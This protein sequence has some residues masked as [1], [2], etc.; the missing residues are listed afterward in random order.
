MKKTFAT[1]L[2]LITLGIAPGEVFAARQFSTGFEWQNTTSGVE[3]VTTVSTPTIS[4]SVKHGGNASLQMTTAVTAK[5]ISWTQGNSTRYYLRYYFYFTPGA[6]TNPILTAGMR[7]A[8]NYYAG[9]LTIEDNGTNPFLTVRAN[10]TSTPIS[11]TATLQNNTWHMVEM[12]IDTLGGT[13]SDILTVRVD[14]VQV[15]NSA[16]QNMVISPSAFEISASNSSGSGDIF[17]LDDIAVD[18]GGVQGLWQGEG[19]IVAAV[20]NAAGFSACTT[21]TFSSINEIPQSDTS[22]GGTDRCEMTVNTG[23]T[24]TFNVTDSSA[25][26]IDSYDTINLLYP[27]ARLN[28]AASNVTVWNILI[29]ANGVATTTSSGFDVGDTTIRTNPIGTINFGNLLVSTTN[30]ATSLAW[31]PTGS[32]SIDS[33]KIGITGTDF[34]PD[35]YMQTFAVMIEYRDANL[36]LGPLYYSVGKMI[37]AKGKMSI[38]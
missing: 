11:N 17:Y 31:T 5:S 16:T 13:N 24:A 1:L 22:T 9:Y 20:P 33:M 3:W 8:S 18:P 26:G 15:A 34:N 23:Q 6:G 38:I 29:S 19:K 35:V 37:I 12:Y 14:G 27:M 7:D 28:E 30:P 10:S 32:N 36:P 25:L 21:G 4:T 2:L